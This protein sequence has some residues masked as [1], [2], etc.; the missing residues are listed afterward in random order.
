MGFAFINMVKD[1]EKALTLD[2]SYLGGLRLEVTMAINR[3]E[4]YG[5]TGHLGCKQCRIVL[6]ERSM[7][8]FYS[9]PTLSFPSPENNR[10]SG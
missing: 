1:E 9:F 2:G 3:S 6:M 5:Y 10:S 8:R 4:Y 7:E